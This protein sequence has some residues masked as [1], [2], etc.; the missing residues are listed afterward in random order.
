[1]R[2]VQFKRPLILVIGGSL[3]MHLYFLVYALRE[4]QSQNSKVGESKQSIHEIGEPRSHRPPALPRN[5][6]NLQFATTPTANG[7]ALRISREAA[8]L[9]MLDPKRPAGAFNPELLAGRE[10]E[11]LNYAFDLED[12]AELAL[13]ALRE[14][15]NQKYHEIRQS[16]LTSV[17]GSGNTVRSFG[18]K[19]EDID[20][21]QNVVRGFSGKLPPEL[22]EV[23]R[24][25]F[26]VP[27]EQLATAPARYEVINTNGQSVL[28]VNWFGVLLETEI[29]VDTSA[30]LVPAPTPDVV[31]NRMFTSTQ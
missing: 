14:L 19:P 13:K 17:E 3:V 21:L 4:V 7:F 30:N 27:L 9:W 11:L 24:R 16:R 22:C 28:R 15:L 1:V 26:V 2:F 8:L 10:I 23:V 5:D 20:I 6:T 29:P 18:L 25:V 31:L 12:H